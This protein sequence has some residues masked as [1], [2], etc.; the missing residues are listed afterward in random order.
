MGPFVAIILTVQAHAAVLNLAGPYDTMEQCRAQVAHMAKPIAGCVSVSDL[1][2]ATMR[3]F[4]KP[5]A[6]IWK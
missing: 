6:E 2:A 1:D 5:A 4:N 3:L